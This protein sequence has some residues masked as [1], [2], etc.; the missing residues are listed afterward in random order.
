MISC[1]SGNLSVLPYL[2]RIAYTGERMWGVF[3]V[4]VVAMGFLLWA[5]FIVPDDRRH[6]QQKLEIVRRKLERLEQSK[7]ESG[8]DSEQQSED[9][10]R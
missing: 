8:A 9:G 4:V 7:W 10:E 1:L 6:H 5:V 3:F 2:K